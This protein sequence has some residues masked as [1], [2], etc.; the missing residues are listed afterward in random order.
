MLTHRKSTMCILHI[1]MHSS[2]G[3]VTLAKEEFQ[4][5]KFP[6]FNWTYIASRTHVGLG[7]K[8]LVQFYLYRYVLA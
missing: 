5:L 8:F 7:P 2:S 3:H 6:P 1:L 4:L